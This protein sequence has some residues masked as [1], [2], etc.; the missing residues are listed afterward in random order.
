MVLHLLKLE[1]HTLYPV[2]FVFHYMHVFR[3]LLLR[4][5]ISSRRFT[6]SCHATGTY[7]KNK[8]IPLLARRSDR[9]CSVCPLALMERHWR[10][11]V[12][13]VVPL[14]VAAYPRTGHFSLLLRADVILAVEIA[15]IVLPRW[16]L[17]AMKRSMG[18]PP[19]LEVRI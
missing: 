18:R 13:A 5:L 7:N 11:C 8:R 15:W 3:L 12:A 10:F 17:R 14:H 19:R 2:L 1:A 6:S 4:R 16:R 9:T